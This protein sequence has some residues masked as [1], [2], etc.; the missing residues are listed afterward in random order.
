MKRFSFII[1]VL[2]DQDISD[3]IKCL[4]WS[5]W[6]PEVRLQ[7]AHCLGKTKQGKEVHDDLLLKLKHPDSQ[8][9]IK[10]VRLIGHLGESLILS[11]SIL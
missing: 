1:V 9:R 3:K 8:V 5:D 10:A 11:L 4:M 6:H 2:Y 7:A